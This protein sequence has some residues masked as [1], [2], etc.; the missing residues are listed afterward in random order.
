MKAPSGK[1]LSASVGG[2]FDFMI[3]SITFLR[4]GAFGKVC[5]ID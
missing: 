3:E 5:I 4:Y 2:Y 1:S